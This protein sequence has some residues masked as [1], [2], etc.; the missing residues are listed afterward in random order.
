[1]ADSHATNDSSRISILIY[2]VLY[3]NRE[4]EA[5]REL[6]QDND[7]DMRDAKL[8]IVAKEV[9]DMGNAPVIV[10]GDFNDVA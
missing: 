10:A 7:P 9:K 2:N 1:M 3:D 4:V 5:L 6:I 8:L